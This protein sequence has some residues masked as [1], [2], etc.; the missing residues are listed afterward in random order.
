MINLLNLA[1]DVLT[2]AAFPKREHITVNA[3]FLPLDQDSEVV[4]CDRIS[5][6]S[7]LTF[8]ERRDDS[9]ALPIELLTFAIRTLV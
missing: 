9:F 2:F 4:R 5:H 8:R 6:G 7:I 3:Y 1:N